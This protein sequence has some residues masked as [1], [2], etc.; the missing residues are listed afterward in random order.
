MNRRGRSMV[1][2]LFVP[3]S[4]RSILHTCVAER[5]EI[6]FHELFAYLPSTKFDHIHRPRHH[7]RVVD[8]EGGDSH[9][10]VDNQDRDSNQD[11]AHLPQSQ[12]KC[13][14]KKL[15]QWLQTPQER[16]MPPTKTLTYYTPKTHQPWNIAR[17]SLN[18]NPTLRSATIHKS[19]WQW[20][21]FQFGK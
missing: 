3:Y 6:P 7:N 12:Q 8:V 4:D 19:L 2:Q 9:H 16:P 11:R 5:S 14:H 17:Q 13:P 18:A 10:S 20:H 1:G 21:I 15:A